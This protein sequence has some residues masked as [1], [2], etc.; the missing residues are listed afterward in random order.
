MEKRLR[1]AKDLLNT[2]G[3]IL[4]N[5]D[6]NEVAPLK[7]LCDEIFTNDN[8]VGMWIWDGIVQEQRFW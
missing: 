6:D 1:I 7:L 3:Y 4:I 8:F 2:N 5:I